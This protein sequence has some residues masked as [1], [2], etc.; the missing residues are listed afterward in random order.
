M[1]ISSNALEWSAERERESLHLSLV[2]LGHFGQTARRALHPRSSDGQLNSEGGDGSGKEE[3]QP[4]E[5]VHFWGS[6]KLTTS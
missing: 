6:T 2:Q 1:K 3:L 5:E 4:Y